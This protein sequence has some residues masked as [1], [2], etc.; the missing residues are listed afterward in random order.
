MD[1]I[2][3]S[4]ILY[5]YGSHSHCGVITIERLRVPRRNVPP[6]HR[7]FGWIG[8]V[9]TA[10]ILAYTKNY[11]TLNRREA[12]SETLMTNRGLSGSHCVT[13]LQCDIGDIVFP[14]DRSF[15]T[16]SSE[17]VCKNTYT[18]RYVSVNK[19]VT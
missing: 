15:G 7:S 17:F 6:L 19:K 4:S 18:K 11:V 1:N 13:V 10:N 8:G 14:D 12:I 9:V 3:L 5:S 2:A 16:T